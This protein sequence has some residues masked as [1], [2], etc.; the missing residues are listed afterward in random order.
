MLFWGFYDPSI[1]NHMHSKV[2]D[3]LTH[4]ISF[5]FYDG[6]KYW[7]SLVSSDLVAIDLYPSNF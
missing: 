7:G 1:S 6:C 2:W 5:Q 4:L 3:E